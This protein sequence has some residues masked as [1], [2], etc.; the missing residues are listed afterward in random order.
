MSSEAW[1]RRRARG[2]QFQMSQVTTIVDYPPLRAR[3]SAVA[4]SSLTTLPPLRPTSV[5]L[6]YPSI[7]RYARED[8]PVFQM[9]TPSP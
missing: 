3:G 6:S 9:R 2:E 4:L 5:E 7:V 1:L 8:P